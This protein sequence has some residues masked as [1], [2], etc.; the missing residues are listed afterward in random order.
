MQS[1]LLHWRNCNQNKVSQ[2][3]SLGGS[4]VCLLYSHFFISSFQHFYIWKQ[5]CTTVQF[6]TQLLLCVCVCAH[7]VVE[8][9]LLG[10]SLWFWMRNTC[11][12]RPK[13]SPVPCWRK[14]QSG[15]H[16]TRRHIHVHECILKGSTFRCGVLR[17]FANASV[18]LRTGTLQCS[19]CIHP[20]Q[21]QN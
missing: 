9:S 18:C 11:R 1:L 12:Q 21:N 19:T 13:N 14:S 4:S 7:P 17:I 10:C 16:H 3:Y 15:L 20:Y 8:C 5:R 6:V 2:N